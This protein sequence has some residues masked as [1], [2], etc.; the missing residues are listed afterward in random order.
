MNKLKLTIELI[1]KTTHFNNVR[2][3]L[4][5]KEWDR[6]RKESY[7]KAKN[8]C[9]ICGDTGTNQGYRHNLECHEV[10]EYRGDKQ[11]LV[12]LQSLCPLCHQVKHIGRARTKGKL[13][14][15]K[16]HFMK[17]NKVDGVTMERYIGAMFQEHIQRSKIKWELNIRILTEKYKVSKELI[18]EK[19]VKVVGKVSKWKKGK[20]PTKK[21]RPTRRK[22]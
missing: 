1:P 13:K 6:L 10:W 21:K 20:T 3:I 7:S 5:K 11:I 12:K 9:E 4:P 17:I 22:K 18:S 19:Y 16:E 14:Q 15:L 8:K 2:S